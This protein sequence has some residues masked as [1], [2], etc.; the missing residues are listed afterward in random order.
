VLAYGTTVI[1]TF[2]LNLI[3][4]L[5]LPKVALMIALVHEPEQLFVLEQLPTELLESHEFIEELSR[6]CRDQITHCQLLEPHQGIVR[7][8]RVVVYK[9]DQRRDVVYAV[10]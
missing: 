4:T 7:A 10:F 9:F 5:P 6:I 2:L 3:N 8:C 1:L